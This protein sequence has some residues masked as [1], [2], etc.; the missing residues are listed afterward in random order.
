MTTG[1]R[2]WW[3]K[4][5][6]IEFQEPVPVTKAQLEQLRL[7]ALR[8]PTNPFQVLATDEESQRA[9][10]T[11]DGSDPQRYHDGYLITR[12]GL[13]KLL[14]IQLCDKRSPFSGYFKIMRI[15]LRRLIDSRGNIWKEGLALTL[16]ALAYGGAHL[17][18]WNNSFVTRFEQWMWRSSSMLTAVSMGIFVLS[19]YIGALLR[20][21]KNG[22][23]EKY[24]SNAWSICVGLA[25]I[26]VLFARVFLFVEC[27]IALRGLPTDAYKTVAWAETWPHIN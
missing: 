12:A 22:T 10:Q 2:S 6:D 25:L 20:A 4:P 16:I 11:T 24:Y 23:L 19:L 17:S 15:A 18:T 3:G 26:P 7:P 21:F 5:V 27:F 13:G 8:N 9:A 1:A 14:Y